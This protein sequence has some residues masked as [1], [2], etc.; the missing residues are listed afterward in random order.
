MML[1]RKNKTVFVHPI[2]T[3]GV[4]MM[5]LCIHSQIRQICHRH[6]LDGGSAHGAADSNRI[7]AA[8]AGERLARALRQVH[9]RRAVAVRR[10][11]HVL[12][13]VPAHAAVRRAAGRAGV[14]VHAH[15]D[16]RLGQTGTGRGGKPARPS[17]GEV[18]A[19]GSYSV[20]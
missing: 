15:C 17:H 9:L 13:A 2:Y 6:H 7:A 16:R 19:K 14:H 4:S 8:A 11:Q 5:L 10:A 12:H 3:H 20:L 1:Q 18:K